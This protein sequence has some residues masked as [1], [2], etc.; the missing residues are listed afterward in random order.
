[1]RNANV[2]ERHFMNMYIY[3][4][5]CI[6]KRTSSHGYGHHGQISYFRHMVPQTFI[7]VP[8]H[9]NE[10]HVER[11]LLVFQQLQAAVTRVPWR[12]QWLQ[13][14]QLIAGA[15]AAQRC[16]RLFPV[17]AAVS[18]ASGAAHVPGR[19]AFGHVAE[20]TDVVCNEQVKR[21]EVSKRRLAFLFTQKI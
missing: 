11:H 17:A 8:S 12:R 7:P 2:C 16:N 15:D 1:M 20:A 9:P 5:E 18:V 4:F 19:D 10:P 21:L 3:V 13:L 6:Y 14:L